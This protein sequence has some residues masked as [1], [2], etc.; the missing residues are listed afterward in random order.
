MKNFDS[1]I[2]F[3]LFAAF[4]VTGLSSQ[5]L[6]MIAAIAYVIY[7]SSSNKRRKK[8][9]HYG[10]DR[11]RDRSRRY[12]DDSRYEDRP[13]TQDYREQAQRRRQ[14]E[15]ARRKAASKPKKRNNPFKASGISK[16]KDYDYGGAIE[17]FKKALEIDGEDIAVH[18]NIACAYS[19]TEDKDKSFYHLSQAVQHGFKDFDKI[20]THDALAY[21]RIQDEF[22]EF[23]RN[24]FQWKRSA[25]SVVDKNVSENDNLL[26][27]LKQLAELREKGLLTE[28][29]FLMQKKRLLK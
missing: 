11:T 20:R 16:F 6:F 21:L 10:R 15:M 13:R 27:Q 12:R 9:D 17:D 1:S 3:V 5:P 18:F 7:R 26:E 24:N 22:E 2:L 23:E 19:L 4:M 25:S 8:E 28:E 14:E 29:E